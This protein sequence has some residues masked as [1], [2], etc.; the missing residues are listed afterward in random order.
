MFLS[1]N[2]EETCVLYG[3]EKGLKI[4]DVESSRLLVEREQVGTVTLLRTYGRSSIFMFTGLDRKTLVVWE[5][6]EKKKLA[7]IV[8]AKPVVN[9][10][11][12]NKEILV[13]TLEKVHIYNFSDLNFLKTFGTTQNPHGSIS[14]NND[15]TESVLAFPG[16]KQGYVHIL[17]NGISLYIKAHLS[18][19][20][21]IALNREGNLLATSSE[22]GTTIRVFN[23]KTGE[24]VANFQRG[25]TEAV[26]NHISWSKDS[27]SICVSSSRGTT[28]VFVIGDKAE[29]SLLGYLPGSLGDYASSQAPFSS[30]KF[31][32]P[33]G[34]S[35]FAGSRVKHFARDG[36]VTEFGDKIFDMTLLEGFE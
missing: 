1:T 19:L 13:S 5:D 33:R 7:E 4:Y 16:M 31:L 15:R 18:T 28:H 30:T 35:V 21:V 25:A 27:G 26:I 9:A 24:K 36:Y 2:T 11:F 14:S 10:V 22:K 29:P 20:R 6:S 23:T 12:S 34:I 8:F 17:R 32:H 3:G